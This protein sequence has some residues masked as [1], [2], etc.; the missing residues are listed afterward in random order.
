MARTKTA[1]KKKTE[2]K[3]KFRVLSGFHIEREENPDYDPKIHE[4][5]AKFRQLRYGKG[6][7]FESDVD[8]VKR[9]NTNDSKKFAYFGQETDEE[10]QVGNPIQNLRNM[11]KSQLLEV[12]KDEGAEF[13]ASMN[14]AELFQAVVSTMLTKATEPDSDEV[15]GLEGAFS[16]EELEHGGSGED[17]VE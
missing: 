2:K 10:K 4:E 5:S 7:V 6:D 17:G 12:A 9:Y 11:T 16:E 13:T 3:F 15:D 8:C 14:R 1:A